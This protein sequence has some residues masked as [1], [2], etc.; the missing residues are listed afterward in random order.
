MTQPSSDQANFRRRAFELLE[1]G[2]RH[3]LGSRIFDT[4]FILL[5][6]ANVV[7]TIF[8]T[9]AEIS[10]SYGASIQLFDRFCVAVF[11]AEYI[12]RLWAAPEHPMFRGLSARF[13][14]LRFAFSPMMLI[15]LA[16][17]MAFAIEALHPALPELRLLRLVRFLKLGRYT[18][19][20]T[21]I[22]HVLSEVR[23]PL[24]ACIVLFGGLIIAAASVMYLLEGKLQPDRLGD[25]PS[26]IWWAVVFLTKLGQ[27]DALPHTIGGKLAAVVFML[28]GI[29]FIA[30]PVGIIGRGFYDEIRRRDFVV[31]FG[32]VSRVPL[33]STL[34]ASTITQLVSLLKARKVNDGAVIIHKGA[35]ADAMY[36]VADGSVT[37]TFDGVTRHLSEGD[38]FGEMALL[39]H[40][41]RTATVTARGSCELLVLDLDDFERLMLRCPA[42][43]AAVTNTAT[44][45]SRE[46]SQNNFS[47]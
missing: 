16:G 30:L 46:N 20:L 25:M 45:R 38:F 2:K 5:I 35:T 1:R 40:G 33:F 36:F 29:G 18:P 42:L 34:D 27:V 41:R 7:A 24:L 4:F 8:Q 44:A 9:N 26:A 32:L 39:S 6:L 13:P 31:T 12:A 14:R 47:F 3:H 17:M 28:L 43:A 10:A 37:V 22:W 11:L 23:R 15:D 21:S 19:A